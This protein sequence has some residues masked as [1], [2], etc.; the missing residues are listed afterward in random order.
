MCPSTWLSSLQSLAAPSQSSWMETVY[1]SSSYTSIDCITWLYFHFYI[2][3]DPLL[4]KSHNNFLSPKGCFPTVLFWGQ[5][6]HPVKFGE[7][8]FKSEH[9]ATCKYICMH[10]FT[11]RYFLNA[12]RYRNVSQSHLFLDKCFKKKLHTIFIIQMNT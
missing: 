11:N 3:S 7:D 1:L 6:F 8:T 10:I 5:R 9:Y 4:K 12:S 2:T